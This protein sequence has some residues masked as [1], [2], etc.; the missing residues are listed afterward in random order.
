MIL[1]LLHLCPTRDFG[2]LAD[3][4]TAALRIGDDILEL[5]S[6]G[7]YFLN[8][9]EGA[10]MPNRLG[11]YEVTYEQFPQEKKHAF[12]INLGEDDQLTLFVFKDFV[13]ASVDSTLARDVW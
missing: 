1:F 13:G 9:V 11:G 2:W 8:G 5:A 7:V 10:E 3:E 6:W 12:Y 4:A